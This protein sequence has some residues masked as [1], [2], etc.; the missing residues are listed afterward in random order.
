LKNCVS[1]IDA[2]RAGSIAI[3]ASSERLVHPRVSGAAILAAAPHNLPH[4]LGVERGYDRVL[5]DDLGQADGAREDAHDAR[6]F[7]LSPAYIR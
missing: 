5:G 1:V 4:F 3:R 7:R 2:I 6:R